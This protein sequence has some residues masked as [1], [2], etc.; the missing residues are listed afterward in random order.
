MGVEAGAERPPQPPLTKTS[1][2]RSMPNF[3]REGYTIRVLAA[4]LNMD[5]L[6]AN[7]GEMRPSLDRGEG[8]VDE[9]QVL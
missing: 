9:N 1:A 6:P 5:L 3:L 7:L 4:I 2:L 8:R